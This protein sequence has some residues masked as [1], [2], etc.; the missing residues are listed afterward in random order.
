MS[1]DHELMFWKDVAF[2][3]HYAVYDKVSCPARAKE[4]SGVL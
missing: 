1:V 3:E 4:E 2:E